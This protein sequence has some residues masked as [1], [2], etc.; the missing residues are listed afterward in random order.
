MKIVMSEM[1]SLN[2][3]KKIKSPSYNIKIPTIITHFI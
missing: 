3:V 1:L 2:P